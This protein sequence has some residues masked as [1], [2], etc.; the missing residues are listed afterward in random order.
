MDKETLIHWQENAEQQLGEIK[1]LLLIN[2][3]RGVFGEWDEKYR[4]MPTLLHL[5]HVLK[6]YQIWKK[7]AIPFIEEEYKS[8]KVGLEAWGE[9]RLPPS[10]RSEWEGY[11]KTLTELME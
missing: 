7:K 9:D 6:Y 4:E 11:F 3:T 2:H 5:I 10:L 1:G 8:I